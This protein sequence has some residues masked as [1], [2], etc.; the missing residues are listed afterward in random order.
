MNADVL[1]LTVYFG[2]RDRAEHSYLADVL[3]ELAATHAVQTSLVL[4]GVLGFGAKQRVRTDRLLSLSEDLPLVAVAVDEPDRIG[5]LLADLKDHSFDGLVTL[6]RAVRPAPERTAPAIPWDQDAATKLTV[7]VGRHERRAG[8]P[9]HRAIVEFLHARGLAGATVLLGVDGT[10][11]GVR[12]RARFFGA[13]ERV[14]L[15]IIAV[16]DSDR[17][18]QVLPELSELAGEAELTLERVRVCKRDGDRL[19][20]PR[21]LPET[22]PSGLAVWQKLMVY[23]SERAQVDGRPL[24]VALVQE[25]R[26]QGASGVTCVRG[27]WGY[28]GDHPPHGD[29][30]WQL[31]RRVPIVSIVVDTPPRIQAAFTVVDRLTRGT[32]LVTSEM[33]PAY[34]SSLGEHRGGGLRLA[35]RLPRQ[36]D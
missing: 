12:Q 11:A 28:H 13:N 26:R 23:G 36:G 8:V 5:S 31:R 25:L 6:E 29:S 22:D 9:V 16:G 18:E 19:A 2:E 17:I 34:R 27:I 4:R 21:E 10:L 14:P 1:K 3:A 24:H 7:Y 30:F 20:Y 33:V 15:M 32:G 35:A